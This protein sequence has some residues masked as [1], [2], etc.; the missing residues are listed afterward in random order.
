M[1]RTFNITYVAAAVLLSSC[2]E[3]TTPEAIPFKVNTIEDTNPELYVQY[4]EAIKAYKSSEHRVSYVAF[5]NIYDIPTNAA[6]RLTALPDSIDFVELTNPG[7][8]NDWTAADLEDLRLK[9]GTRFVL[10]ISYNAA[11][12]TARARYGE[13]YFDHVPEY[14]DSLLNVATKGGF[15][16]ITVEYEGMGT[17]HAFPE[18]LELLNSQEAQLFPRVKEWLNANSGKL[19]FFEGN[20]QHTIDHSLVLAADHVIL[21]TAD[22]KSAQKAGYCAVQAVEYEENGVEIFKDIKIIFAARAIP[23]D[24]TDTSTGR[25]FEGPAVELITKWIMYEAPENCSKAGIAIYN[26]QNDCLKSTSFYPNVKQAI[27][28]LNPNS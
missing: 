1:K 19:L 28:I 15:D 25:Y 8:V 12:E 14:V 5:D 6:T 16:G 13:D 9:F 4:Q 23:N 2:A 24:I 26:V 11:T 21:P 17:L 22:M 10:R 7:T 18:E 27:K 20:P 3:W